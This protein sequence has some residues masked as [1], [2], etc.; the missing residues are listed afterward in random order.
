MENSDAP[1]LDTYPKPLTALISPLTRVLRQRFYPPRFQVRKLRLRRR[2]TN[3]KMQGSVAP[4]PWVSSQDIIYEVFTSW[5]R[6]PAKG[7]W[8]GEPDEH[9]PGCTRSYCLEHRERCV[10]RASE[11]VKSGRGFVFLICFLK[12]EISFI[13]KVLLL[14]LLSC[15]I[16][17]FS[18]F[19]ELYTH[20]LCLIP[21]HFH[22]PKKKLIPVKSHSLFSPPA[23]GNH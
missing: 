13:F 22:Q 8:D 1:A 11:G 17:G 20:H 12:I 3:G 21:K 23:P 7:E 2:G 5:P 4:K 6:Q 15:T 16:G 19:A 18:I 9:R 14:T 10:P